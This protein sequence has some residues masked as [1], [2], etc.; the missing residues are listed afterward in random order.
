[1][2]YSTSA[3]TAA[4]HATVQAAWALHTDV[5]ANVLSSHINLVMLVIVHNGRPLQVSHTVNAS[6]DPDVDGL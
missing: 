4:A 6:T 5:V 2:V 3:A 1:M